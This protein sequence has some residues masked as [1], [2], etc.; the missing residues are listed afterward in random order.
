MSGHGPGRP[1]ADR[2]ARAQIVLG[3][4]TL[5][6]GALGLFLARDLEWTEPAGALLGWADLEIKLMSYNPLGALVTMAVGAVG[7]AAGLTR[8]NALAW[9]TAAVGGLLAV[10]VL[11]QW[12]PEGDNL[13]GATGR[14]LAFALVLV[15][16]FGTTA[17][18]ARLAPR[19]EEEA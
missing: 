13:F 3:A 9:T 8:R 10:Q 19:I 7:L 5:A 17:V 14:N 18:L 11:I 16:G 4:V 12:R 2:V 6:V 1:Y 15:A